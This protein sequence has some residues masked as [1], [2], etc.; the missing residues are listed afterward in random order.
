MSLRPD[1]PNKQGRG[2]RAD[3]IADEPGHFH[4]GP[5]S[6]KVLMFLTVRMRMTPRASSASLAL[7]MD[8]L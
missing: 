4:S 3:G 7:Q 8:E 1:V 6:P 2:A 5:V